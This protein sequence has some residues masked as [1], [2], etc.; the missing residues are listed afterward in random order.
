MTPYLPLTLAFFGIYI[1]T[2]V[3]IGYFA[4]RHETEDGFMIA[5]RQIHGVQMTA[6]MSAGY[7]D[8]VTLS[9]Y[10]GYVYQYGFA[11]LALFVG[12]SVGFLVFRIFAPRIKKLGD[13]LNAYSM[14]EFFLHRLGKKNAMIISA[15]LLT[16]YFAYLVVN[17][18]LSGKVLATLFP[19]LTYPVA[20]SIGSIVIVTYL[21]LAGFKAVVRTDFFQFG[22]M[23]AMT[24]LAAVFFAP[25][26]RIDPAD[27]SLERMG[28]GNLVGFLIIASF[29]VMVGPDVWQRAFAAKDVATLKRGLS[30][31]AL[32]LPVL[33]TIIAVVGIATKQNLPGISP[34]N[35]LLK[36]F[37][38][39]L[40][41]AVV[42]F[43]LVLLYAVALSSSDTATFVFSSIVT[44]DLKNY[45]A[46]F[47]DESMRRMTRRIIVV[48]V[49]ASALV[50][51]S[52]QSIL[53]IAFSMASLNLG[54]VPVVFASFFIN[55]NRN[56]VFWTL[57]LV[58]LSVCVLAATLT[59][60]PANSIITLPTAVVALPVLEVIARS[61]N[62]LR[63]NVAR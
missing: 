15:F 41:F 7:F 54:L 55:L 63:P 39:L 25:K 12:L 19:Q 17:F 33:A 36:A 18:I 31:S 57:V 1:I 6:T 20:V 8:G 42:E 22:I 4:S 52:Y 9:I 45:T 61:W 37:S 11:G 62:R 48:V 50:A 46:R 3:L 23:I 43:M 14:P 40:P 29:T 13:E 30:Y 21:L 60:N 58:A 32:L 53:Q 51:M 16:Q 24:L 28:I 35:A 38:A 49:I 47:S 5:D 10:I 2:L 56:A 34:E 44:R 26:V 59:L 27:L